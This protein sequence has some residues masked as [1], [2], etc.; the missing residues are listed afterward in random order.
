M[1]LINSHGN[2]IH[3]FISLS[4]KSLPH[5]ETDYF[6]EKS[7]IKVQIL[8]H[9]QIEQADYSTINLENVLVKFLYRDL[10]TGLKYGEENHVILPYKEGID[11]LV[12]AI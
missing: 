4:T 3:S 11:E 7:S 12:V 1:Q 8:N 9:V 2:R 5:I 10:M 6:T